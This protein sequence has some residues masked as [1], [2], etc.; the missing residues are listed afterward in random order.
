MFEFAELPR[1][2]P[3]CGNRN[4]RLVAWAKQREML[5]CKRCGTDMPMAT[6]E[7]A[8]LL[9]FVKSVRQPRDGWREDTH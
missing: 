4:P 2:C 1:S 8:A 5:I 6:L 7:A 3:T 9:D